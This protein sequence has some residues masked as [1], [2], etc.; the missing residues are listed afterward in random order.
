[1][2]KPMWIRLV[3]WAKFSRLA[4]FALALLNLVP[5]AFIMAK[6]PGHPI[7]G[8]FNAAEWM[9]T[10]ACFE[11]GFTAKERKQQD[12]SRLYLSIDEMEGNY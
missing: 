12:K 7:L 9:A 5:A 6:A 4:M 10:W 1:M 8:G 11:A 3:R 2:S